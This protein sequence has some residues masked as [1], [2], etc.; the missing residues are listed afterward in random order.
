MFA[1]GQIDEKKHNK[2][3]I[4]KRKR[5]IIP[6]TVGIHGVS[7]MEKSKKKN[8]WKWSEWTT[9]RAKIGSPP[10]ERQSTHLSHVFIW[11][12]VHFLHG[13]Q[14]HTIPPDDQKKNQ[15]FFCNLHSVMCVKLSIWSYTRTNSIPQMMYIDLT[16][17][18]WTSKNVP[19]YFNQ[20]WFQNLFTCAFY[21]LLL[22]KVSQNEFEKKVGFSLKLR[23]QSKSG[24][25]FVNPMSHFKYIQK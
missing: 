16:C 7:F 23:E 11:K 17:D 3:K 22:R 10:I 2:N 6:L 20:T 24:K 13:N 14:I 12:C 4:Q 9:H 15:T 21:G 18:M 25:N 5:I 8:V 1:L 19:R